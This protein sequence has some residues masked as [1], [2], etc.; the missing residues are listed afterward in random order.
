MQPIEIIFA[1][2]L[3][4]VPTSLMIYL[5]ERFAESINKDVLGST[6]RFR[7]QAAISSLLMG[8]AL[9]LFI[10]FTFARMVK[11]WIGEEEMEWFYFGAAVVFIFGIYRV[12]RKITKGK[13]DDDDDDPGH[14]ARVPA[15]VEG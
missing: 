13:D 6:L 3:G 12:G 9:S 8:G 7:P 1:L 4:V 14:H 15:K 5:Y 11:A 2:L 10:I